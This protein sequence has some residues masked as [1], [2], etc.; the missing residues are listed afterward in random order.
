MKTLIIPKRFGYPT[1]DIT[2]NGK[3]YTVKSGEEITTEDHIAE[4]IE[5][6]IAL[7]PKFGRNKSKLAQRADGSIT[8]LTTS[9]LEG[10]QSISNFAFREC[11]KLTKIAIPNSVTSIGSYAFN[12]C[13]LLKSVEIPDNI[14][15]IGANAFDWCPALARVYLPEIPPTLANINA[16]ANINTACIF[17][18][19]TQESLEAY[20]TAA[21]WSSLTGTYSFVVEEKNG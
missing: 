2:V 20:R 18:C 8:E 14:S 4:A 6:A 21:Y 16:F 1:L 5:N 10:V 15:S 3:E 13:Y 19:K 12:N 7:E 17:Y 11:V 9:D